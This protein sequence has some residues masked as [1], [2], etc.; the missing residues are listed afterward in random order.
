MVNK[1]QQLSVPDLR[2]INNLRG[3]FR[4]NPVNPGSYESLVEEG[5]HFIPP[6]F[7]FCDVCQR[8]KVTHALLQMQSGNLLLQ[9]MPKAG[10]EERLQRKRLKLALGS[11]H[12][13]C[14]LTLTM[15]VNDWLRRR[16]RNGNPSHGLPPA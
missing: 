14:A 12:V 15:G 1:G 5:E 16:M 8:H 11:T 13:H 9:T 4:E 6:T 2:R 7:G 10:L 3:T